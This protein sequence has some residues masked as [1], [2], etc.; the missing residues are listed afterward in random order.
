VVTSKASI[1][2]VNDDIGRKAVE[3]FLELVEQGGHSW[4][5]GHTA[6]GSS[7]LQRPINM[8]TGKEYSG[9]NAVMLGLGSPYASNRWITYNQLSAMREKMQKE[10]VAEDKLPFLRQG[11]KASMGIFSKPMPYEKKS[12]DAQSGEEKVDKGM[13]FMN[14]TF[15]VFNAEQIE[16]CPGQEI[17]AGMDRAFEPVAGAEQI[18]DALKAQTGLKIM[19]DKGNYY[20]PSN[21]EIHLFPKEAFKSE[22]DFYGT[23]LHE[24]GHSMAAKHRCDEEG[25]LRNRFGD[26]SYAQEE[27]RAEIT[28]LLL[29][30]DVGIA[31]SEDHLK[32]HAAYVESWKRDLP[33]N[34]GV[35]LSA[36]SRADE[37]VNAIRK[38]VHAYAAEQGI[39]PLIQAPRPDR[40]PEAA[41]AKA[42]E[43]KTEAAPKPA[44]PRAKPRGMEMSL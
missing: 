25:A 19:F 23:A 10:G 2:S 37:R 15:Y 35:L 39:E 21:D 38:V 32:N 8:S 18:M 5:K 26:K 6:S 1:A 11:E 27:L 29:N 43:A 22:Y 14:S 34:P 24:V 33:N 20:R 44:A 13:R 17:V 28:S 36:F 42:P 9:Y 12:V 31:P 4:D 40:A 3:K 16:N 41:P 30:L 7:I